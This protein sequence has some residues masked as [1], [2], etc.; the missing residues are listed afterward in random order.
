MSPRDDCNSAFNHK[1][2]GAN[3]E[4][5]KRSNRQGGGEQKQVQPVTFSSLPS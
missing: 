1:I 4:I 2:A 5:M 3:L